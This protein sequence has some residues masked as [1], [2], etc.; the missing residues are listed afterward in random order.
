MNVVID[1]SVAVAW[2]ITEQ[3]SESARMWHTQMLEGKVHA[4]VPSLHYLEFAN[5]LRSYV[6]RGEMEKSLAE[7]LFALHL[8][9]PIDVV[10]PP[11][12]NL[13]A[14][15][16]AFNT[17]AYDASFIALALAHDCP[18]ITAERTTTPWVVK[19]GKRAVT[20]S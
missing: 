10:E 2:Y 1:T 11:R 3:F 15:A 7:D 14:T 8:D 9:A 19:L 13:L 17:T 16:L 18:L 20:I 6:R 5:V 4:L 12:G